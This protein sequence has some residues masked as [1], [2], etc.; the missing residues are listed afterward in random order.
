M[1][2]LIKANKTNT[3]QQ[4]PQLIIIHDELRSSPEYNIHTD[5]LQQ[6]EEW[7]HTC[8]YLRPIPIK[9]LIIRKT[10]R[11]IPKYNIS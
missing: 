7:F 6:E 8:F 10:F 4:W 2:E 9:E 3:E 1:V 5:K 11:N